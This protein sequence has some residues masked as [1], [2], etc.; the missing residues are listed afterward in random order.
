[1]TNRL[2]DFEMPDSEPLPLFRLGVMVWIYP[3]ALLKQ[4]F[5]LE[6]RLCGQQRP[7]SQTND[8]TG[9]R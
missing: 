2:G 8:V 5:R 6:P 9:T 4:G 7:G 1:M 3:G